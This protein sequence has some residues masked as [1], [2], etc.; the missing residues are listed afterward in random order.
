MKITKSI[1]TKKY[2]ETYLKIRNK[3]SK[4]IDFKLNPPQT[5]LY[6]TI[7]Q[8]K[9]DKKPVRI[10]ILKSRQ[11]GFS[12]VTEAIL[13]KEAVTHH[14]VNAGIIAHESKA[15]NNLFTMSKLFY[16]SLPD[17]IKPQL[18]NRN[19]QEL[20]FNNKENT[21]LNSKISCMTAGTDGAGRSGTYNKLHLSEFAFWGGDKKETLNALMQTVP[22]NP[23]SMVII[24]S[25]AN[26]YEFFKE[27]WDK[28]VSGE[29]DFVPLFVGWNEL[30]EYQMPYSGFE[31]TDEEKKIKETFSLTNEQLEWRRWCIRN[32]CGGDVDLFHQE[33]PITPEEAF[34]STGT[35]VFDTNAINKRLQE[36]PKP[37][38][39]G[40]FSYEYDDTLPAYGAI[41][42]YT[43]RAY[44]KYKISNIKWV[45]DPRGYIKIYEAPNTPEVVKYGIGGDTAGEGSDYFT[46]HVINTKT[47]KQCAV[48]KKQLN[49]D[50]YAKQLY[51]L[52]L[53]Y[54]KALI[55]IES[56]FDSFPIRELQRLGYIW[57][58]RREMEEKINHTKKKEFGFRTDL[59]TRPAII[60]YLVELVRDHTDL[61]NDADTLR[62]ML[63][64]I[65]NDEGRAEAQQGC[66]DDLVM[67][68]AIA[69]RIIQQITYVANTIQAYNS[70]ENVPRSID[71]GERIVV[72]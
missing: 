62:E 39:V 44:P 50:L 35:C 59:R 58:Y 47:L 72:I 67:G 45:N 63:H 71:E 16:D 66:H 23:E 55:G 52:G 21:G 46:A 1:N 8:Q 6:N 26:G 17:P 64:F 31:L 49:P 43:G 30:E 68:L 25:T 15:T 32:N 53:Y 3:N 69:Y 51:C 4:I 9:Q 12:T 28:A 60:S 2:I 7:K 38:K 61:I 19:A 40:Y 10:I 11:M 18:L 54:N 27:M 5:R 14:N 57:Q 29:S 65:F 70:S 34:L 20:V 22:N 13:F 33:Y 36:V 37:I 24:E 56:N 41:N 42:P 48:L